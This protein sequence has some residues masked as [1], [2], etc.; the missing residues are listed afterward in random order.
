M[1]CPE[2]VDE[3]IGETDSLEFR[4]HRA[5][6]AGCRRDLVELREL[7]GLYQAAS[8]ETYR[9]GVPRFRRPRNSWIPMAAAAA[10]LIGV[11]AL[12]L[13]GPRTEGVKSTES[14]SGSAVFMRIPLEPWASDVRVASALD[15][16]WRK[17]E[18]LEEKKR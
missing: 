15:D 2:F 3:K 1:E 5:A 6:C 11:F 8:T 10:I 12:I 7:L 13:A 18:Q 4:E 17:L 14:G 16:C 9:G